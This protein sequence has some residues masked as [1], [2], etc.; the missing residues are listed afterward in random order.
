VAEALRRIGGRPEL[1]LA[2]R[3]FPFYTESGNIIFDTA[4]APVRDPAVLEREIKSVPGVVEV[5]IFTPSAVDVYL[6]GED[7]SV[8]RRRK[9]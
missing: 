2:A 4:F 6:I 9:A 3:S 5:G 8:D 1:R 7:G